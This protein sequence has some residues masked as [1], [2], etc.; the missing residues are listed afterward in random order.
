MVVAK[1][2]AENFIRLRGAFFSQI[3]TEGFGAELAVMQRSTQ[4]L[5]V[6]IKRNEYSLGSLCNFG[7]WGL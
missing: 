5:R 3:E 4:V 7:R 2:K 6:P 1:T